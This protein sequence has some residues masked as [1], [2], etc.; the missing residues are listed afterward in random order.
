M[1]GFGNERDWNVLMGELSALMFAVAAKK[2]KL[3]ELFNKLYDPQSGK[4][5]MIEWPRRLRSL[6]RMIKSLAKGEYKNVSPLFWINMSVSITYLSSHLKG[7][8]RKRILSLGILEDVA[9]IA[10]ML[11]AIGEEIRRFEMWEVDQHVRNIELT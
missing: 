9:V 11:D 5:K 6:G 1:K 4:L 2:D 10:F 8:N 7:I 3:Q